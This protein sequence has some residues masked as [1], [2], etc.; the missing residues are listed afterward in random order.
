MELIGWWLQDLVEA[1][2][3]FIGALI[4]VGVVITLVVLFPILLLFVLLAFGY[5]LISR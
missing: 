2:P 4:I 5:W 3:K 1:L